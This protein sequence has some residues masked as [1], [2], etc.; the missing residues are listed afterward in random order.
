MALVTYLVAPCSGPS[1]LIID[2]SG[3]SLPVIGGNY[4]LTFTSGVIIILNAMLY[5][6]SQI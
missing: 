2:F 4:Y 5:R 3:S 6:K 1:S